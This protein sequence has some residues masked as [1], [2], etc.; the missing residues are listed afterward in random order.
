M[1]LADRSIH[2]RRTHFS[3]QYKGIVIPDISTRVSVDMTFEPPC[4]EGCRAAAEQSRASM[5][6]IKKS[7]QG[8]GFQVKV[9]STLDIVPSSLESGG[10]Y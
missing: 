7:S 2:S 9:A 5:A 4:V 10:S 3:A 1:G 6:D 8:L